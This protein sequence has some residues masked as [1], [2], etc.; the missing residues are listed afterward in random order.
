L[1]PEVLK[2]AASLA[3]KGAEPMSGN[4]YKIPLT[5]TLVRRALAETVKR[6]TNV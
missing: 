2:E 4:A 5:K 1:S 6:A 3:L